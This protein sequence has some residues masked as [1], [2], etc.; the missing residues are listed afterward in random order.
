MRGR[1][2]ASD[3]THSWARLTLEPSQDFVPVGTTRLQGVVLTG[4]SEKFIHMVFWLI[5]ACFCSL[6][7]KDFCNKTLA[8]ERLDLEVPTEIPNISAIS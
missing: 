8:L 2:D 3:R 4:F 1:P 6:F 5:H 7:F